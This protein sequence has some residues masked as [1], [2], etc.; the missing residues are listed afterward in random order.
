[1]LRCDLLTTFTVAACHI[2][3]IIALLKLLA[4]V[5][6]VHLRH[7]IMILTTMKYIC[8]RCDAC[9][10]GLQQ[11]QVSAV[12]DGPARRNRAVVCRQL[13]NHRGKRAVDQVLST[14]LN[15][16]DPVYHRERKCAENYNK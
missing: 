10:I 4:A 14:Q 15:S 2:E 6:N 16:N 8:R 11:I 5:H 3:H 7:S 13:D 9:A 1:M 12:A